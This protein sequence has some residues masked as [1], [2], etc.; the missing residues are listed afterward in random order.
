MVRWARTIVLTAGM[1]VVTPAIAD[2]AAKVRAARAVFREV[3]AKRE[4]NSLEAH[5]RTFEF[6]ELYHDGSRVLLLESSGAPRYYQRGAGS[7]DSSV[8]WSHYYDIA[9]RLRFVLI[10][11]GAVNG[12]HVLHRIWFDETGERVREEQK[13]VEGPGYP[14][15]GSPWPDEDLVRDPKAAFESPNV[16]PERA[17]ER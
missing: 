4:S 14:F 6:C 8:T 12:T 10:S 9:G 3:V 17:K 11:A 7:G 16:C 2:D 5:A 1:L 15:P 13:R